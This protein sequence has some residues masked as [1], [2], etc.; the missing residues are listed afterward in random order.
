MIIF[1]D[2]KSF[3]HVIIGAIAMF[4]T[5]NNIVLGYIIAVLY[6]VYQAITSSSFK[7]FV[8]DTIEFFFGCLITSLLWVIIHAI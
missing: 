1:D 8:G 5:L 4:L 7:E 3:I 2:W 6:V